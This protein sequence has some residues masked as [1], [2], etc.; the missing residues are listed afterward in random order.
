MGSRT[1]PAASDRVY[2]DF[3]PLY[4]WDRN[5]RLVNVMLPGFRRDQL[6]VQ[7][8]SKPTLRLMGERLITEN[9]W[10]RF[11]LELPLLSDY[12]TDSVTAKFEGAK[13][14]IKFGELSLTKPKETLITPPS[15]KIEQQ[16]APAPE[17]KTNGEVSDQK[18]PQNKEET[19]KT[20][21]THGT[22][23]GAQEAKTNDLSET[24]EALTP[25]APKT[26]PVSRSKTRLIDFGLGSGSNHVDD[27]VIED[28]E[29][30]KN[31]CKRLVKWM[32]II[33]LVVALVGLGVYYGKNALTSYPEESYFQE[34]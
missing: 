20:E 26:R 6:K 17:A 14:S 13:L 4:E 21:T 33:Y 10:R 25:T 30:G 2:E 31:K 28:L 16:K 19:N 15:Q 29:A 27:Q 11:N 34:L 12:D 3:V 8:T 23:K 5:E 18:T 9:R 7:V 22:D 1:Q 32:V 24:K